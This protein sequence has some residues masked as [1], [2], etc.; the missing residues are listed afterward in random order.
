MCYYL[1]IFSSPIYFF[2]TKAQRKKGHKEKIEL[3][4]ET[5]NSYD[6]SPPSE[7]LGEATPNK[8]LITTLAQTAP[9]VAGKYEIVP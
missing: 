3:I 7:G 1:W 4:S 5:I 8:S 2:A 9:K 6:N